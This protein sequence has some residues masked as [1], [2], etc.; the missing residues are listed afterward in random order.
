[1][2]G[3]EKRMKLRREHGTKERRKIE[4]GKRGKEEDSGKLERRKQ[5]D[6]L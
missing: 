5:S 6:K 4:K 2:M 3:G 1:M